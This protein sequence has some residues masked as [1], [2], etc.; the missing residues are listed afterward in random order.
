MR[1]GKGDATIREKTRSPREESGAW[2]QKPKRT[3]SAA[4]G[5]C[6]EDTFKERF[7]T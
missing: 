5:G 2:F 6:R 3:L 1:E 4:T 7:P